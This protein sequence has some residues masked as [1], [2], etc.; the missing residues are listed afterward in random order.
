VLI[1]TH[2]GEK[3]LGPRFVR[4]LR[5]IDARGSIRQATQ[6]L[7]LGYRHA[8]AWI[9]RAEAALDRP[10]VTRH[11]GGGRSRGAALTDDGR[12][13][14]EAYSL[15]EDRITRVLTRA[16]ALFFPAGGRGR[17]PPRAGAQPTP[18]R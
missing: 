2:E 4:L 13:V 17:V 7:S 10:L 5:E 15:V 18:R 3:V 14:I 11:A 12:A 6:A 9:Q 1:V 8:I 16:E